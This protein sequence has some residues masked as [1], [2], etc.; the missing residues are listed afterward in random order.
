M[1]IVLDSAYTHIHEEKNPKIDLENSMDPCNI[2][3]LIFYML[4][5][6]QY[7][8]HQLFHILKKDAVGIHLT[9]KKNKEN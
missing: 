4:L 6:I 7:T 2:Q 1:S 3:P 8:R 5:H 9:S